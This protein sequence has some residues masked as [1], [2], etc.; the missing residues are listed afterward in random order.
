VV[1]ALVQVILAPA[2]SYAAY[3]DCFEDCPLPYDMN[4][5]FVYHIFQIT[6][7]LFVSC[8][9]LVLPMGS[10]ADDEQQGV[11]ATHPSSSLKLGQADETEA[12]QIESA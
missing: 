10:D 11:K 5:N 1:G 6:S 9:A 7:V 8:G 4:H 2:C 3:E 12:V